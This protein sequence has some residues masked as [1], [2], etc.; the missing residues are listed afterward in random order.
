MIFQ[1]FPRV[2]NFHATFTLEK[3][4]GVLGRQNWPPRLGPDLGE[5]QI[6][7]QG[8]Y[9]M[10]SGLKLCLSLAPEYEKG[11]TSNWGWHVG[12]FV[13]VKSEPTSQKGQVHNRDPSRCNHRVER[14]LKPNITLQSF[15]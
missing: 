6:P 10:R 12:K 2:S 1:L 4:G 8:S 15:E 14:E 3:Q 11:A 9:G 13:Y 7:D 5:R